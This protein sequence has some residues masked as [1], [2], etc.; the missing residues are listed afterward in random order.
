MASITL[1]LADVLAK[2]QTKETAV[3][4]PLSHKAEICCISS[5]RNYG[6]QKELRKW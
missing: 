2:E 4:F 6:T 5:M 3:P 1:L